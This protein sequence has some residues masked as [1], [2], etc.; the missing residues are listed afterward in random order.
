MTASK[1]YHITCWNDTGA[2]CEQYDCSLTAEEKKKLET[3]LNKKH[4][5]CT[6]VLKPKAHR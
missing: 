6:I 5:H 1:V 4:A 2:K 3:F